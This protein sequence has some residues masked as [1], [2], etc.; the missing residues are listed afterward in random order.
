MKQPKRNVT[1]E[2]VKIL[3]SFKKSTSQ[4]RSIPA[5]IWQTSGFNRASNA[6]ISNHQERKKE[7]TRENGS[8]PLVG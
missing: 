4:I 1:L 8:N 5:T 3:K 7:K 6:T 2:S